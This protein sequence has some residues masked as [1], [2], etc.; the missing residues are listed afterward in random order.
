MFIKIVLPENMIW[1]LTP[2]GFH[3]FCTDF[4]WAVQ[5]KL[6]G[7]DLATLS[8]NLLQPIPIPYVPHVHVKHEAHSTGKE[9]AG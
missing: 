9:G 5:N 4:I 1:V 6:V 7:V 2:S 3:A 8:N